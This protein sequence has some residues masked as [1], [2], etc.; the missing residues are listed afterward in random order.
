MQ[1]GAVDEKGG[2]VDYEEM[3]R[4]LVESAR[5]NRPG[6]GAYL[7]SR[8]A[9]RL[10]GYCRSITPDLG[11]IDRELIVGLA[12]ENALRKIDSYDPERGPF[13]IW[14]RTFVKFAALEWRRNPAR[15]EA[16]DPTLQDSPLTAES[17]PTHDP[18]APTSNRL[19]LV[20]D[21][22]HEAFPR[23]SV[24]DQVILGMRNLEGRTFKD[25]AFRLKISEA[26]A[27]QRHVRA[28]ARLRK[29]LEADPRTDIL[30]GENT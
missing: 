14:L 15:T 4:E 5:E 29:L 12:V 22:L 18:N 7:V 17:D 26:A 21:A 28:R 1:A 6:A 10:L 25:V 30:T 2:P 13:E 19:V 3:D 11:D 9:P 8:Y 16:V 23:L 27:R 20:I 24:P